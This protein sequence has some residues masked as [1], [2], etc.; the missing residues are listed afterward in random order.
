MTRD[1]K[2]PEYFN[3]GTRYVMF[4]TGR[5]LHKIRTLFEAQH[6]L[7]FITHQLGQL[8]NYLIFLDRL[9]F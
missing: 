6:I 5:F 7:L 1:Q 3:E 4:E 2:D 8:T 9:R